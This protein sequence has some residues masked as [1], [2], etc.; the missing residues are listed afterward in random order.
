MINFSAGASED[1]DG[2]IVTYAWD[3]GDNSA[4]DYNKTVLHSYRDGGKKAVMLSVRDNDGAISNISQEILINMPPVANFS[5]DP[6]KPKKG[7]LVSFNAS[8]S[9]DPDGKIQRY[10]WDFGDGKAEPEV[11]TSELAFQ[12]LL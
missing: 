7:V 1:Q 2:K 12:Y 8:Q 4:A 6:E 11:Y 9:F 5:R 10:F 3:F